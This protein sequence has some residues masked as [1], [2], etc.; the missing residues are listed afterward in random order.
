[1]S[2]ASLCA[3]MARKNWR[4]R[5]GEDKMPSDSYSKSEKSSRGVVSGHHVQVSG[6]S[7][8]VG[9]PSSISEGKPHVQIV[10][11]GDIVK[12]IE[13]TCSCGK[14]LRLRCVQGPLAS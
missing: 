9:A 12:F 10:R 1:L 6:H 14:R 11:D 5:L 4:E 3:R 8:R 2:W 13:V 7:A